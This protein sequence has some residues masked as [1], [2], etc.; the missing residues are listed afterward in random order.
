MSKKF[1]LLLLLLFLLAIGFAANAGATIIDFR[2]SEFHSADGLTSK[3]FSTYGLT[4]DALPS[5][6]TLYHDTEDGFGIRHSYEDDEIEGAESLHLSFD[7]AMRLNGFLITDLFYEPHNYGSG[8]YSERGSYSFDNTIWF[9]FAANTSQLPDPLTNGELYISFA[10]SPTITDIWF[11]SLGWQNCKLEDHEFSLG[12]IKVN[13]VP[14]PATMLLLGSG[15]VTL[16]GIGRRKILK[17][18]K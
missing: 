12:K 3:Y 4:V 1:N 14:E 11:K 17:K 16:A 9:D 2:L 15:L 8:S 10:S 7:T 5:G 13:P 6:S 18:N